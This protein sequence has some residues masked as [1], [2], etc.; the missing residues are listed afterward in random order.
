M[1]V[2]ITD[3]VE[4]RSID[5]SYLAGKSIAI[6]A[7][8]WIY[9]FLA[10][11]RQYDG[12]PLQTS[13][14]DVTS[15]LSG[16]FYRT[17]KLM[18]LGVKPIYVFDGKPPAFKYVLAARAEKKQEARA[19]WREALDK[20]DMA[21][22]RKAAQGTSRLT[23]EMKE[24]AKQLLTY[25]GVPIIQAPSEGEAQCS[26]LCK[27]G[28]VFATASQDADTLLFGT[29][30]LVRNLSITGKRKIPGKNVYM[31]IKPEIVV[32]K[33]MLD[34]IGMDRKQLI[35]IGML[36]GTDFCPGI[37]GI[38]PKKALKLVTKEKTLEAVLKHV[39]WVGPDPQKVFDFFWT[40][41]TIDVEI[42][43]IPLQKEK[44]LSMLVDKYEFSQE[45]IE[46][47]II[48]VDKKQKSGL[49]RFLK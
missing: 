28:K 41:P 20:G 17:T 23:Q 48:D 38:G 33:E 3:L 6:D 32:L 22:A 5:I 15:H 36:V 30:R 29:T 4:R 49:G 7:Y 13:N 31:D 43:S 11:I 2:K 37:H 24:Q 44:V 18:K 25:L 19:K 45:R 21:S 39:D 10:T 47:S 8:N 1:G 16:L 9:Q 35:I 34:A 42:P 12:T 26:Y 46:R 27:E 14:G 40:P